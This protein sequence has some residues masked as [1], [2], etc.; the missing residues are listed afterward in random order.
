MWQAVLAAAGVVEDAAPHLRVLARM[1]P[2][3]K[4]ATLAALGAQGYTTMMCG[5]GTNDVGALKQSDVG[6]A[7]VTASIIAPPPPRP[8]EEES[9]VAEGGGS[10]T[11]GLRKRKGQKKEKREQQTQEERLEEM[12]AK[13][14]MQMQEV[15]TIKLGDASIAAAFTAKS[16][17]STSPPRSYAVP[18]QGHGG[19][20]RDADGPPAAALAMTPALNATAAA[21]TGTETQTDVSCACAY[22]AV[23][24]RP[25]AWPMPCPPSWSRGNG[26]IDDPVSF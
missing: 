18:S 26:A 19:A 10:G 24:G 17:S 15:P 20:E 12:R 16:A 9:D 5:D 22:A 2:E 4:Q 8:P 1:S 25:M 11:A 14:Q 23:R 21:G 7:L 3:Q 6:V 13:V